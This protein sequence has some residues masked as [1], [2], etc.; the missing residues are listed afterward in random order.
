MSTLEAHQR[1]A[2]LLKKD[3][4]RKWR[5]LMEGRPKRLT[6]AFRPNLMDM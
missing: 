1:D 5:Y 4:L 6:P 2:D 3:R